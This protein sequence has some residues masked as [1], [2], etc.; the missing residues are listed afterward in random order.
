MAK[1][2]G[3]SAD[4]QSYLKRC[5]IIWEFCTLA[6][7]HHQSL[8]ERHICTFKEVTGG[9]LGAYNKK[10][11]PIN[12]ELM[13]LFHEAEYIMKCRP[14]GKN[15]SN[16]DDVEALQPIDLTTGFLKPSDEIFPPSGTTFEDKF[17]QGYIYTRQ[18]AEEWWDCWLCCYYAVLRECQKWTEPQ[19]NLRG[20]SCATT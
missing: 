1:R 12:F 17:Q 16:E 7:S 15:I 5:S 19:Q 3:Y 9:V 2:L 14:L 4:V 18:L 10:R 11:S 20:R 13:T 6:S 8:V